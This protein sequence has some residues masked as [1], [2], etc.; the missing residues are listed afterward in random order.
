M[1]QD[2]SEGFR[3]TWEFLDA[4]LKDVGTIGQGM[5]MAKNAFNGVL[6]LAEGFTRHYRR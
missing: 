6:G 3:D 5:G 1:C 2:K 4:R